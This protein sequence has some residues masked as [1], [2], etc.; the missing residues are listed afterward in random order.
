MLYYQDTNIDIGYIRHYDIECEVIHTLIDILNTQIKK[1]LYLA[2]FR[3]KYF[4]K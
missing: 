2:F 1:K 3:I 4:L